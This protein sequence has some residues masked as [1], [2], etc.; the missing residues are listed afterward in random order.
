VKVINQLLVGVHIAAAAEAMAFGMRKGVDPQL[1]YEAISSGAGNS[2]PFSDRAP[3][4]FCG[5]GR[6][7]TALDIFMKDLRLVLDAAKE[8]EIPTPLASVAYELFAAASTA[9]LGRA[10][11]SAVIRMFPGI[12]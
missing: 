8:A 6:T 12:S 11:D 7:H 4:M 5:D 3:R 9:G 10:D 1:L 2:W